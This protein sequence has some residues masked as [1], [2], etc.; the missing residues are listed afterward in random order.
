MIKMSQK[1]Y[2]KIDP[3]EKI[4][5]HTPCSF[6]GRKSTARLRFPIMDNHFK[7]V[8]F[9]DDHISLILKCLKEKDND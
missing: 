9:C 6:C 4:I 1:E 3:T 7:F 2:E 5:R 8:G